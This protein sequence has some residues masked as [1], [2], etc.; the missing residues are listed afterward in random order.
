MNITI[1]GAGS[2]GIAIASL[3]NNNGHNI[4]MWSKNKEET[5]IM[6]QKHA[7]DRYLPNFNIPTSIIAFHDIEV[8]LNE[9]DLVVLAVP[10]K[11]VKECSNRISKYYQNGI[12]VNLSKGIEEKTLKLLSEVIKEENPTCEVV[13][14]SGPSHAEEVIKMNP[15]LV[16]SA[17]YNEEARKKVANIFRNEYFRVY[18][19]EDV[20]G[21]EIGGAL[22]NIVALCAGISDGLNLG[23][24]AKAALMTRGLAEITRLAVKMGAKQETL[25]GLAG[26]GDLVVTCGSK[27]S[28]NYKAGVLIGQGND[29]E[30]A[31]SKINM[32]VEGVNTIKAAKKLGEKY[33]VE[34]PIIEE[35][36][37][38]LFEGKDPRTAVLELM[39]RREK[40]EYILN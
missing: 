20:I 19:N 5:E 2:W 31:L 36:N 35:A 24:N 8:A 18:P 22:K 37:K 39:T 11:A 40:D 26:L 23:D 21:V 1:V 7:I 33:K 3:L 4:K 38:I 16:T 30:T 25:F 17:S 29:L 27:H 32:V 12:I 10:S 34:L 15:T 6:N 28:R 9:A 13:T 14:V